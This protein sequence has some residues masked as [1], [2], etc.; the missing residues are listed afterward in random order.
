LTV[1]EGLTL[2]LQTDLN[3]L[4]RKTQEVTPADNPLGVAATLL[5]ALA[6]LRK[7]QGALEALGLAANQLGFPLRMFVMT[8]SHDPP[9]CLINPVIT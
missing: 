8:L 4:R 2:Q 1:S 5:L 3:W 9:I 7:R 6:A